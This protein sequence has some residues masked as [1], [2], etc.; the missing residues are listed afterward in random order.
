[1]TQFT[2]PLDAAISAAGIDEVPRERINPLFGAAVTA[3]AAPA[4]GLSE[5]DLEVVRRAA[6]APTAMGLTVVDAR[7]E[8]ALRLSIDEIGAV[9][10]GESASRPA[11]W[12]TTAIPDL[13][14]YL[15]GVLPP[16]GRLAAP[17]RLASCRDADALQLTPAQAADAR[18]RLR[19]GAPARE[20]FAS[21]EGLDPHL[22][23]ALVA[24]GDRATFAYALHRPPG[25]P[26]P[27]RAFRMT[28]TWT[29]GELG[30]YRSESPDL[31]AGIH[32]VPDGDVL[33]TL[34]PLLDE[35][36][37]FAIGRETA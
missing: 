5:D 7:G 3:G 26:H 14:R 10:I 37:R 20:V 22:R 8:R 31:S 29:C 15:L 9:V 1:M 19:A 16:E 4:S 2:A 12:Q 17:P 30:L 11:R 24:D 23:D 6:L 28:R 27:P 13:P 34:Q 36:A 25:G 33:G 21:L 32:Q 35:G 18:A